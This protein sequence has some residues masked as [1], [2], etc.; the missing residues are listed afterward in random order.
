MRG[1]TTSLDVSWSVHRERVAI[2]IM[3]TVTGQTL[4]ETTTVEEQVVCRVVVL[5]AAALA[6]TG[7]MSPILA[8]VLM[9]LSSITVVVSSYRAKTFE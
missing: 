5:T 9:P 8:A 1:L 3:N 2:H 6:M 4:Y 7:H